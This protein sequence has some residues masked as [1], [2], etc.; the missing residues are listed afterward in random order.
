MTKNNKN[1]K[2]NSFSELISK[3][4]YKFA[5]IPYNWKWRHNGILFKNNMKKIA[6]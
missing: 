4:W 6:I 5:F 1:K 2:E 3:F